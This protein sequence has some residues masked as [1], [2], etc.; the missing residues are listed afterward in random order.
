MINKIQCNNRYPRKMTMTRPCAQQYARTIFDWQ[1]PMLLDKK[2]TNDER[3]MDAGNCPVKLVSLI[4]LNN[5]GKSLDIED[6]V[7]ALIL[8]RAQTGLEVFI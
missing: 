6:D 1:N 4:K 8:S 5:C 3:L 2:L 7:H